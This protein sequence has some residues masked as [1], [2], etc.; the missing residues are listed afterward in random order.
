MKTLVQRAYGPLASV[1]SVDTLPDPQPSPSEVLVRVHYAGINP[2]DWKLVEGQYK[3]MAR[4]RPPCGVGF[5]LA[6][7]VERV[8]RDVT[9]VAP[10]LRVAGTIPAFKFAPGAL[11]ELAC[12]PAA[13]LAPVPG[14][15]TLAH[16]A[17]MPVAGMSALQMCRIARV[18]PGQRVLINGAAGGVGHLAVQIARSLGANVTATGSAASREFIAGLHPDHYVDYRADAPSRW[19]GPFDAIIDGAASLSRKTSRALLA[20]RGACVS[21]LPS[22]PYLLFDPILNGLR[23]RRWFALMLKPN[24]A[25]LQDLLR[26]IEAGALRVQVAREFAFDSAVEALELSR[27]GHVCG[28]LVV[29]L[30]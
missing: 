10:G 4:A 11:A 15:V 1:L 9:G 2:L 8:G 19:G 28:K 30:A 29:R 14:D 7:V 27:T 24:R 25:D 26:R 21:T 17:A 13:T 5:D 23:G 18:S 22:F 12:V 3:W 6:G 16:A 20:E